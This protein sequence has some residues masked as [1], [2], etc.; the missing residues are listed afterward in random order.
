MKELLNI[1]IKNLV[2]TPNE[3]YISEIE[4]EDSI[5]LEISVSKFDVGKIIGK[6]GKVAKAI[7]IIAQSAANYKGKK[8]NIKIM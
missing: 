8:I 1:I 5:Y 4:T 2:D 7:R 3:V 6:H